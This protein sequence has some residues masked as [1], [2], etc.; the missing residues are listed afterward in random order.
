[1][2]DVN[3]AQTLHRVITGK[4]FFDGLTVEMTKIAKNMALER[5]HKM[6][7]V[8]HNRTTMQGE[9]TGG[10]WGQYPKFDNGK[11]GG[12]KFSHRNWQVRDNGNGK[13][14][15]WNSTIQGSDEGRQYPNMLATGSGWSSRVR[16]GKH[17]RLVKRGSKLFSTQMPYGLAPWLKA[18]KQ[19]LKND[20]ATAASGGKLKKSTYIYKG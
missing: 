2:A 7:Q 3:Y 20:I 5:A 15:I 19:I 14:A 1:M 9:G 13:Y 18:Q 10:N 6:Q 12:S 11:G 17:T 8:L 16:T 4:G